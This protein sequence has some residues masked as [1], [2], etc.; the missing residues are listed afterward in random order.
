MRSV[1]KHFELEP[2]WLTEALAG[3]FPGAVVSSIELEGLAEGTNRRAR[4]RLQY[5]AGEGPSAVFLKAPGPLLHRAA[6]SVLGAVNAEAELA[7]SGA[8]LPLEHAAFLSAVIYP[9]RLGSIVLLEDVTERGGRPNRPRQALSLSEVEDGIRGLARLHAR[10]WGKEMTGG[11]EFIRPFRLR[12]IWAVVSGASLS[13]ARHKLDG[14][15]WPKGLSVR[16]LEAQFRRGGSRTTGPLTLLHGDP[17]PGNTYALSGGR[18]GFYD[19]QLVRRGHF[20]Q[21]LS[22]FLI[23]SLTVADRR[24]HEEELVA[25]YLAALAEAVD[26]PPSLTEA[27]ACHRAAPAFGL[28]TWLHTLSAGTFQEEEDCLAM[29]ERFSVAYGDLDT[30]SAP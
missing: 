29:I 10:Y 30:L 25:C 12:P 22:Y 6:L 9:H 26:D 5:A 23:G 11:L 1:S 13:R 14:S 8:E 17:H 3:R 2:A 18:T 15:L 16:L 20:S 7:L 24:H 27:L 28:A 21:D 19:W 4:I